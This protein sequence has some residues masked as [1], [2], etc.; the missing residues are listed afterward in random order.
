MNL[1][2]AKISILVVKNKI[3]LRTDIAVVQE[4]L[5][6]VFKEKATINDI[7]DCLIELQY[8]NELEVNEEINNYLEDKY[9]G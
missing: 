4:K 3:N 5:E 2:K 6:E 1:L 9:Y 7:E 8:E